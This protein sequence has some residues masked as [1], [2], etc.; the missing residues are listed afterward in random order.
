MPGWCCCDAWQHW[1]HWKDEQFMVARESQVTQVKRLRIHPSAFVFVYSSD[2]L[3]PT[4]VESVYL[5]VFKENPWPN[6]TLAAASDRKSSLSGPTGVKMS[7]P[8]SYVPPNYWLEDTR[9]VGGAFG[10]LTE[11][12]PGQNPLSME[13]FALT[14]PK[15][16]YWPINDYWNYHCGAQSGNFGSLGSFTPALNARYGRGN[17]AEDFLQKSELAAFEGHKAMF[18][19]YS[20]NKYTST[21]VIQ[22]MLNNPFPEMI[23]HLYDYYFN[24]SSTYFATKR[25]CEPVHIQYSYDDRSIWVVNSLYTAQTNLKAT[26]EVYSISATQLYQHSVNIDKIDSDSAKSLFVLP[27]RIDNLSSSYFVRLLLDNANGRVSNN[28]YWLSTTADVL[29]WNKSTWYDTPIKTYGNL[30]LLQTLPKVNLKVT[31]N[32][33][34]D[35]KT[36]ETVTQVSINNPGSSIALFVHARVVSNSG[37]DIWPILWDDNYV[38]LLPSETRVLTAKYTRSNGQGDQVITEVWNNISGGK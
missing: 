16:Q 31:S 22:W 6:P 29:D 18:E 30:T 15:D 3:P 5:Q 11:G 28:F 13:S 10:F 34:Q 36:G 7:G 23:W 8:Y 33:T 17:S 35:Q 19:G 24:P 20:R 37:L 26:A 12:G 2:E 21:G 25:A 32:T 1:S 9:N 38:S 4:N 14:V 27:S